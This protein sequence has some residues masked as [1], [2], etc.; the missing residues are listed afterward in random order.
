MIAQCSDCI[1]EMMGFLAKV[2]CYCSMKCVL[3]MVVFR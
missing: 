3:A 1:G 2:S